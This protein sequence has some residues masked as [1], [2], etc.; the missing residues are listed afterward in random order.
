M[1][2]IGLIILSQTRT[3]TQLPQTI[4]VKREDIQS[5]VS[6]SGTLIGANTLNLHFQTSG[7]LFILNVKA[8][9]K[10]YKGQVIG[11]LD[12][13][14][15][16]SI[17]NQAQN[18]LRDKEA[19]LRKIYDDIHLFQYG[20]GGFANVGTG[21]ETE[22]QRTQRSSAEVTRDNAFEEVVKAQR[23]LADTSLISPVSGLVLKA[24]FVEGQNV[25]AG[26]TIVQV[27]DSTRIIFEAE[28]DEADSQK[29]A[30]NQRAK[31]TLDAYPDQNFEGNVSEIAPLA[32]NTSA[33]AT[34]VVAKIALENAKINFIAGLN[35][36]ATII[37]REEK[38]V[39]TIPLEALREDNTV[40]VQEGGG[41]RPKKVVPGIKSETDV[42]IKQGLNESDKI[43]LNPLSQENGSA[44][45]RNPLGSIFRFLGGGRA[46]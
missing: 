30:V 18:T 3:K 26:D 10:I 28:V 35:G 23:A 44:R 4:E 21:N 39:L 38:S 15:E 43:L 12:A 36:Q 2:V 33:G 29:I 46:R 1:V 22:T 34:V 32:K 19:A 5:A 13:T 27:A 9:D 7:R 40:F 6:A 41:I 14:E 20:N 8:G 25:T 37:Q 42:E 11:S 45:T 31:L 24:D 17:L 16:L